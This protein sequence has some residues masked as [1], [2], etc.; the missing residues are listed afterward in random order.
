MRLQKRHP[1]LRLHDSQNIAFDCSIVFTSE[2]KKCHPHLRPLD[3]RRLRLHHLEVRLLFWFDRVLDLALLR[4]IFKVG[5]H[6]VLPFLLFGLQWMGRTGDAD[7][8]VGVL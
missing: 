8:T 4:L 5:L 6:D 3:W 1:H 2:P 7:W